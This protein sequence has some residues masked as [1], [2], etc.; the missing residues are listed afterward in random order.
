MEHSAPSTAH[1]QAENVPAENEDYIA[2]ALGDLTEQMED[3]RQSITRLARERG[4]LRPGGFVSFHFRLWVGLIVL[5][6]I[7]EARR[8]SVIST[9]KTYS[10]PRKLM[11]LRLT[12]RL[13][14]SRQDVQSLEEQ[15][16]DRETEL[17]DIATRSKEALATQAAEIET[18]QARQAELE[19]ALKLQ[20]E[21]L[22]KEKQTSA[23]L[24]ARLGTMVSSL[25]TA[26][27]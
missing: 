15:L 11:H 20:G 10:T 22:Q 5:S 3:L 4:K 13:Q 19:E 1:P 14:Q 24:M 6:P 2:E 23:E 25:D 7:R 17:S 26:L 9:P 16:A 12:E 21:A 27:S 18:L 8:K